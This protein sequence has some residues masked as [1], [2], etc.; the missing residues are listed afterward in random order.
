MPADRDGPGVC[1]RWVLR[2]GYLQVAYLLQ[3]RQVVHRLPSHTENGG[4][5]RLAV[6]ARV[7][8]VSVGMRPQPPFLH[9]ESAFMEVKPRWASTTTC[10]G[11]M[12]RG[13]HLLNSTAIVFL[14][15]RK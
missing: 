5:R 2:R 13:A 15:V 10:P 7:M 8:L 1:N 14:F 3:G 9:R 4:H 6:S 11:N 12:G